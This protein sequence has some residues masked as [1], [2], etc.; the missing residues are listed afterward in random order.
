MRDASKR[1]KGFTALCCGNA[2][3][4]PFV[5]AAGDRRGRNGCY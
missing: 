3:W 2:Y 1:K 5:G 4:R